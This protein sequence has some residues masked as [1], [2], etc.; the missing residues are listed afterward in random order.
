MEKAVAKTLGITQEDLEAK[1][2]AG[3][4]VWSVAKTRGL[5][6]AQIT[7]LMVNARSEAL[8]N[9][10]AAG[11]ITQEQA[12]WMDEHMDQ[13]QGYGIGPG[14]CHGAGQGQGSPGQRWNK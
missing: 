6:D 4:T 8:K 3:E 13:M 14:F 5:S 7:D 9:A 1:L 12:D 11:V 2:A 10:V